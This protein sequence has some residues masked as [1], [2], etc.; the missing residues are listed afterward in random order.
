MIDIGQKHFSLMILYAVALHYI[1]GALLWMDDSVAGVSAIAAVRYVFPHPFAGLSMIIAS[2]IAMWAFFIRSKTLAAIMMVPQQ[3]L[4]MT[5][6]GG[7]IEAM[8]LGHFA[9]GIPR[10]QAFLLAS[11]TPAF[12]AAFGHTA[13]LIALARKP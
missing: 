3:F 7:A 11:Q 6:A 4:L 1:W 5:A 2:T 13:A 9:D 10:T 12:L 8:V